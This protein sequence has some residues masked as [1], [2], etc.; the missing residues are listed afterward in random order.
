MGE[1]FDLDYEEQCLREEREFLDWRIGFYEGKSVFGEC[2]KCKGS[3]QSSCSCSDE[4]LCDFCKK[5]TICSRCGALVCLHGAYF[6]N[7]LC[8]GLCLSCWQEV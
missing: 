1:S 6:M 7:E 2:L 5:H 3:R 8:E 4:Y